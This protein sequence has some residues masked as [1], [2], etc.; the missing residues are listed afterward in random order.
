LEKQENLG[1]FNA[2]I[3]DELYHLIKIYGR[4][5]Q[6]TWGQD[7]LNGGKPPVVK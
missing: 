3:E 1:D 6:E 4:V 2:C 7:K 5:S